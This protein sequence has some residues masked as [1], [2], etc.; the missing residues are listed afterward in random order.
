LSGTPFARQKT[1]SPPVT[2]RKCPSL[3]FDFHGTEFSPRTTLAH[4]FF[5]SSDR[6]FF[7]FHVYRTKGSPLGLSA[8]PSLLRFWPGAPLPAVHERTSHLKAVRRQH[9]FHFSTYAMRRHR[10]LL[11][12]TTNGPPSPFESPAGAPQ[13]TLFPKTAGT[14]IPLLPS[15]P[16]ASPVFLGPFLSP[17]TRQVAKLNSSFPFLDTPRNGCLFFLPSFFQFTW[18]SRKDS[19]R[20]SFFP[21]QV[22][23]EIVVSFCPSPWNPLYTPL[24]FF[25]PKNP[26]SLLPHAANTPFS[27]LQ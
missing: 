3:V 10:P 9:A 14:P 13:H 23:G 19:E 4:P 8:M 6:S 17:G 22:H 24:P 15:P 18:S 11:S 16:T 7:P 12:L 5:L 25:S 1:S 2:E 20:M 27:S 21:P 26:L